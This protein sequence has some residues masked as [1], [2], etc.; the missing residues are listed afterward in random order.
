[1]EALLDC[2]HTPRVFVLL[3][4]D[5]PLAMVVGHVRQQRLDWNIGYMKLGSSKVRVFRAVTGGYLG[6]IAAAEDADLLCDALLE[7]LA[8]AE[9]DVVQLSGLRTDSSAFDVALSRPSPWCRDRF[10]DV[11]PHWSLAVPTSFEDFYRTRSKNTKAMI[12]EYKNRIEKRFGAGLE[13]R[14]FSRVADV[15]S[16]LEGMER[17]AR[18]TYQRGIGVGFRDT[19]ETRDEFVA[20]AE[21]GWLRA[22]L[23]YIKGAP[24]AF[25]TGSVYAGTFTSH[26]TGYDPEL[27]YYHPMSSCA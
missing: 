21:R 15:D 26:F 16:V 12:R 25:W 3:R 13:L 19:P 1:L 24:V 7:S 18:K 9:V 8:H 5:E 2:K 22:Y 14:R 20:S 4:G 27:A 17:I 10:V 23:L 11:E 6:T